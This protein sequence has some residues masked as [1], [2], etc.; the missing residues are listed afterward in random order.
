MPLMEQERKEAELEKLADEVAKRKSK[1][2]AM[3]Q[4]VEEEEG[5]LSGLDHYFDD[6]NSDK[7]SKE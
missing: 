3:M 6:K 7:D 1:R 4:K 5:S 2:E